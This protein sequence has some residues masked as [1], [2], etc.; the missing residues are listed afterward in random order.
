MQLLQT[1]R[2]N[3]YTVTARTTSRDAPL[4]ESC[5]SRSVCVHLAPA[6]VTPDALAGRTVLMI[7]LLRA[8]TTI[9]Y[10]LAAGAKDVTPFLE[11][12]DV[13]RAAEKGRARGE[14]VVC[15]G[16]RGGRPIEGFDLGNSPREYTRDTVAG[17]RVL[18]TTSNGT[19]ALHQARFAKHTLVACLANLSATLGVLDE[20]AAVDILCAGSGGSVTREDVIAA[21]AYVAGVARADA[22]DLDDAAL[23]ALDAWRAAGGGRDVAQSETARALAG[24][25]AAGRH[26][27]HLI[28]LGYEEDLQ[29][30]ATVDALDLAAEFN[31]DSGLIT[32]RAT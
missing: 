5:M 22:A 13:R 29:L 18:F 4:A 7:D 10:A 28:S 9:C 19:R 17:K 31:A 27:R 1:N 14:H 11:V 2:I 32:R 6:L 15:G 8:S 16:E 23:V 30:C 24:S 20:D 25:L 3:A 12:D 21:G 26:G